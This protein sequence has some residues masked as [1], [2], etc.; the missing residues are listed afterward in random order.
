MNILDILCT[1]EEICS[2]GV[3][4]FE[5]LKN[6]MTKENIEKTY[7]ICEDV[8]SVYVA[9]FPYFS[10]YSNRNNISLYAMGKDYHIVIENILSPICDEI[11]RK[12]NKKC[13][14]LVDNSPLPEVKAASL[15][16]V[17]KIGRNGLIFD[18]VYG[19]YVFIGT[20][21]TNIKFEEQK[22]ILYDNLCNKQSNNVFID[23]LNCDM[24]V[25]YCKANAIFDNGFVDNTKC[26]SNITQFKGELTKK[27][28]QMLKEHKLIWGCDDCQTICPQNK[29]IEKTTNKDFID[30]KIEFIKLDDIDGLTKKQFLQKYKNRAFTWRGPKPIIRNIKLKEEML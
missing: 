18:K 5:V 28:E 13:V 25:R 17:G 19:S 10:G 3:C 23:C 11:V 30:D 29:D 7:N 24:C 20:I 16:G 26:L 1:Q 21:I 6:Y 22:E 9:L 12:M 4:N 15:S 14:I 2:V 8:S 27:Q